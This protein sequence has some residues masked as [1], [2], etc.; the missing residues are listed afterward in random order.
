MRE[1]QINEIQNVSGGKFHAHAW[2]VGGAIG[3]YC[4]NYT[5][6]AAIGTAA[7][8]PFTSCIAIGTAIGV[9]FIAAY[10]VA[11]NLQYGW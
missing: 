7:A 1:L 3:A 10:E 8:L 5:Y 4:G 6:A 9:A 11:S 2:V